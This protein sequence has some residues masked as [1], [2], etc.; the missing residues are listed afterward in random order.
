MGSLKYAGEESALQTPI[1]AVFQMDMI[2][3]STTGGCTFEVHAGYSG[4]PDVETRSV[5]I[6]ELVRQSIAQIS[7][8]CPRAQIYPGVEQFDP[9]QTRS[10]HHS[11][12]RQGYAACLV[13]EDFF[14]G[15]GPT[16]PVPNPNPNYHT[17]SD[18][19]INLPYATAIARGVTAAAWLAATR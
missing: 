3:F 12:L 2:G 10:D 4:S 19:A 17:A 7:S 8:A 16:A 13:S 6:A 5:E 15:P 11:F 18:T 1:I 14:T 9:G